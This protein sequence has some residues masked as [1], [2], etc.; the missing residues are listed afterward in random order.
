M[1][2]FWKFSKSR[3]KLSYQT[4]IKYKRFS[5]NFHQSLLVLFKNPIKGT[6]FFLLFSIIWRTREENH[7]VKR[8]WWNWKSVFFD[9]ISKNPTV[10]RFLIKHSCW[11]FS[12]MALQTSIIL[13]TLLFFIVFHR[14][15]YLEGK[16]CRN[17]ETRLG[18]E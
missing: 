2:R 4:C 6:C 15:N 18:I 12:S 3:K 8:I 9:T 17:I 10:L 11:R 5:S 16:I 1:I 14:I 13:F 7:L